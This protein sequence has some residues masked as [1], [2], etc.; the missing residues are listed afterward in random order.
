MVE[1][2]STE[3]DKFV[4]WQGHGK[5]GSNSVIAGDVLQ[6]K[7]PIL[8]FV[9]DQVLLNI[10]VLAPGMKGRISSKCLSAL[11]IAEDRV[12][13]SSGD[14]GLSEANTGSEAPYFTPRFLAS[15]PYV[16]AVGG[17]L[18][19]KI[20]PDTLDYLSQ[21]FNPRGRAYPDIAAHSTYRYMTTL[22]ND[23]LS[24]SQRRGICLRTHR[25]RQHWLA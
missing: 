3:V 15:C 12:L 19:P 9:P 8:D 13:A 7:R 24:L 23:H 25:R 22:S 5:A 18:D 1:K 21:Y 2:G 10:D 4:L 6:I 20:L 11:L 14:S 17:Y 16:T